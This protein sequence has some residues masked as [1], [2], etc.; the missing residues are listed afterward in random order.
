MI[1]WPTHFTWMTS[2]TSQLTLK[3]EPPELLMMMMM[4]PMTMPKVTWLEWFLTWP[5]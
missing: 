5:S 1:S 3:T 2:S 4:R